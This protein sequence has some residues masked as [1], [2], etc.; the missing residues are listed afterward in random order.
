VVKAGTWFGARLGPGADY[1]LVGC[2]VAPGFEFRDFE[3]GRR[4]DL[5][6]RFPKSRG[7]IGR[8]LV[9]LRMIAGAT[10][11]SAQEAGRGCAPRRRRGIF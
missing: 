10:C 1:A 4:D 6:R 9:A 3:M 7:V 8:L 2:T 5:L 11:G